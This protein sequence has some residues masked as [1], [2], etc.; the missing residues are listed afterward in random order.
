[1]SDP[2]RVIY[3]FDVISQWCYFADITLD[4][5]QERYGDRLTID[6]KIALVND[7]KPFSSR[8]EAMAW[9]YDRS[10]AISGIETNAGWRRPNDETLWVNVAAEAARLLGHPEAR[11]ELARAALID[12]TSIGSYESA[13]DVACSATGIA[14]D[15]LASMMPE[16]TAIVRATT[17]EY[18]AL[19]VDVVP[20]L[21]IRNQIGDTAIFSGLFEYST[22]ESAVGEMIR[23]A[24]GYEVFAMKNP[25]MPT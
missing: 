23:A 22:L 11:R 1:M 20:C 25:P 7:G 5:M 4:R 18:K 2:V 3:Y 14:R 24:D 6:W 19:P 10:K 17:A 8:I 21:I 13:L 16:A 15:P 9:V 12:G